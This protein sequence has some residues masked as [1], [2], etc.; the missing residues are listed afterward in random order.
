MNRILLIRTLATLGAVGMAAACGPAAPPAATPG[1][2]ARQIPPPLPEQP[3]DFPAFRETELPNGLR[4]I[5][6]EHHG[7]PVA[8][9]N[10]YIRSG[11]AADPAA[12]AGL[13]GIAADLVTKG[14]ATRTATQIAE[15]IE[16][17]GGRLNSSAGNDWL[18]VSATVLTE[19]VPLAFDLVSDVAL[20]PSFPQTEFD[21]ARRQTLSGLQA[22]LGQPG[23]IAQRRFV[24][25]VY[26][27]EH[28]YGTSPIPGTIEA[29]R[30]DDV[31]AFHRDNFTAGNAMLV[32]S[33]DVR[34]AEIEALVQR[35]FGEWQ[36]GAARAAALPQPPARDQARIY[37]V[38][39]PGSVQSN[40]MVGHLGIRPENPD[41]FPLQ[42]LN[43]IVGGGTDARLFQIL[44]EERGWTY[45]A[46]SR[47][48][49]PTDVGFYV[50]QAEVRTEVT[51]SAVSEILNQLRRIRDEQVP[52]EEFEAAKSFLAGSFPLGIETPGQIAS[53][54]A[55]TRL[56]GLPAEH[57]TQ[58]RDRIRA[59]TP[60]DV[61]RVARDHVRPEQAAIV[62]VGDATRI[63]S[64]LEGIAPIV[65]Y[66]VEGSPIQRTDIEVRAST[67]RFDGSRLRPRTLTYQ[68]TVQGNPMGTV[69]STL[70][71][72][73]EAWVATSDLQSAMMTQQSEVRF[74][75][76][77]LTPISTRQTTAQGPMRL[78][79]ELRQEGSRVIGQAQLPEQMG[80]T[81][82][83]DTEVVA[84]TL[85]PGMDEF[86]LAA[87][88]LRD[89]ATITLPVFDA[90][91]GNVG[92][93][94]YRVT[95]TETITVPA[96]SFPVFRVEVAGGQ[97]PMT[98]YVR[99]EAP[100][101]VVR[102]EIVGA[103]V[104][105]ELQSVQ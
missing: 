84:G 83:V 7:Q 13:A 95:G 63:L 54:V 16:G 15:T 101:I 39:R 76:A 68:F 31:I 57:L 41:F 65:L 34:A 20:R 97:Q 90:L 72:E 46:Y 45:G 2:A 5:V 19:H 81:R 80:G 53:Q 103:P 94:T 22:Q 78:E 105:I 4:L 50:A 70:A 11:A 87:A 96:G 55:Q 35:H 25:E 44:R 6:V 1:A 48:N 74:R 92:N 73:G 9:V 64:V 43:K 12:Q 104:T 67:Q 58:Y 42:V 21:L 93:V 69:T 36:R 85:L 51:D 60:Q 52:A 62:V 17:V 79:V 37:L 102:Q 77:D 49:R 14:T 59:V 30:R 71:R 82:E 27:A 10:L 86:V 23:A 91:T 8:N 28:P 75:A 61:Q 40:I 56:L 24:R 38:H 26:G 18:T 29:I 89:G 47:F 99:Q 98:L 33:G 100:H 3:I 88:D 32:V 66:D